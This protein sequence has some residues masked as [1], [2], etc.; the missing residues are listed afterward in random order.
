MENVS[1]FNHKGLKINIWLDSDPIDPR[2]WDNLGTMA[3]FH[4]RYNLGD[5]HNFTVESLQDFISENKDDLY[6][7]PLYIYEHGGITMQ[8]K[9]FSCQWDSG[10][11]GYIYMTKEKAIKEGID[12]PFKALENE[13]KE[14]DHYIMGNCYGYSIEDSEGDILDSCGG[15]LGYENFAMDEAKMMADY[16]E[17]KLP[18][19][20][21]LSFA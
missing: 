8:S 7:L 10:Q 20:Y 21:A 17:A 13:I 6:I 9:P 12:D 14:Y 2:E 5:K 15:F 3:C 18:K 16:W 11:V 4:N 1:S 19:Q